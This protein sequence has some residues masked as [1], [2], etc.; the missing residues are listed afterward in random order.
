VT[1]LPPPWPPKCGISLSMTKKKYSTCPFG[2]AGPDIA[3]HAIVAIHHQYRVIALTPALSCILGAS[4]GRGRKMVYSAF[5]AALVL[6]G[7][8]WDDGVRYTK[9]NPFWIAQIPCNYPTAP[10]QGIWQATLVPD[11]ML[12]SRQTAS[13]LVICGRDS[14]QENNSCQVCSTLLD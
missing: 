8:I 5:L 1:L 12:V 10:S 7:S 6:L 9:C 2:P 14:G 11:Q 3:F 13:P 4:D